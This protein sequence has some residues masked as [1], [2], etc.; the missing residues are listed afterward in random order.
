MGRKHNEVINAREAKRENKQQILNLLNEVLEIILETLSRT[1][2]LD[3]MLR[4]TRNWFLSMKPDL[5]R[6]AEKNRVLNIL[7]IFI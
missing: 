3:P 2:S 7:F 6:E 4:Q 1:N 5:K